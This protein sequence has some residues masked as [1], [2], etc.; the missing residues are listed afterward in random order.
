MATRK[1]FARAVASVGLAFCSLVAVAGGAE[2]LQTIT[3][4]ACVEAGG[5]INPHGAWDGCRLPGR[6]YDIKI[7]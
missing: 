5:K 3:A 1:L 6:T 7:V 4:G 2:A